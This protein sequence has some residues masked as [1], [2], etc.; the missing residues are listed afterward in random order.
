MN[1]V[2][3]GHQWLSFSNAFIVM[4]LLTALCL[5]VSMRFQNQGWVRVFD[6]VSY[7][8]VSVSLIAFAALRPIGVARDDFNYLGIYETI[9]PSIECGFWVQGARD[10][11]WYSILGFFK[12]WIKGPELMLWLSAFGL[13]IK[14]SVIFK[15][16]RQPLMALL[17]FI[18]LF[19]E[20]LDLTGFRVALASTAFMLAF[21]YLVEGRFIAGSSISFVCGFFHK[22][23]F[24]APLILCGPLL[25]NKFY[26]FVALVFLPVGLMLL[27]L[28]PDVTNIFQGSNLGGLGSFAVKDGLDNFFSRDYQG[29]RVAPVVYYPLLFLG[30]WL[31]RDA[32]DKKINFY[33]YSSISIVWAA[34]FL[35]GF[36]SLP[37]VQVRFFDFMILP[38][39][40]L[41]GVCRLDWRR[42]TGVTIVSGLFVIKFNVLHQLLTGGFVF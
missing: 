28:S 40:F 23:G 2:H 1:L 22:Q 35:W 16:S 13:L 27:G 41:A 21:W 14:F 32:L 11:A 15:L 30:L 20:V 33:T 26:L 25:K 29:W 31:A 18:G 6:T 5:A 24:L 39:V 4:W 34:W 17:L 19:Y 36:A 10:W 12:S 8:I 7:W 42:F 37:E 38:V 3:V 9:C